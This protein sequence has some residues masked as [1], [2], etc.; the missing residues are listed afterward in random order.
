MFL[1]AQ[2]LSVP[3]N[4]TQS[5]GLIDYRFELTVAFQSFAIYKKKL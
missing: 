2:T 5:L 4:F 1:E 3:F